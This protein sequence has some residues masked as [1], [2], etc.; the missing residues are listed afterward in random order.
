MPIVETEPKSNVRDFMHVLIICKFNE[1][2]IK[3]E[4]RLIAT[5]FLIKNEAAI[6]RTT[7]SPYICLWDFWL[8]RKPKFG[9][10]LPKVIKFRL[11]HLPALWLAGHQPLLLLWGSLPLSWLCTGYWTFCLHT[12]SLMRFCQLYKIAI[13]KYV[14]ELR[15]LDLALFILSRKHKACWRRH[16][17][18]S[19]T[20]INIRVIFQFQLTGTSLYL[21]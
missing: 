20:C 3:N 18:H 17:W 5:S 19:N 15:G 9:S 12:G 8:S 7:F 14:T 11:K 16:Q 10:D 13:K 2:P 4:D 6:V 21:W 1:D